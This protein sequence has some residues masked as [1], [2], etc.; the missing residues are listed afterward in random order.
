MSDRV[1]EIVD[2]SGGDSRREESTPLWTCDALTPDLCD[3]EISMDTVTIRGI[4]VHIWKYQGVAKNPT[5]SERRPLLPIVN[6]HGGP[7]WPHSYMLPLKQQACR[8]RDV[9]FYDQAGCGQ[10]KLPP[11]NTTSPDTVVADHFPWLLTTPYYAE[12]ELP[13]IIAHL[14]LED[15]GYHII[16][17]SWELL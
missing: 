16:G 10:S 6:I 1:A 2:D 11:I 5:E 12:E 14:G 9:Y 4:D 15:V 7:A 8:G 13:A 17:S 3:L